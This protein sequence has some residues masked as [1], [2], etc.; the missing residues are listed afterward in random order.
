MI[1]RLHCPVPFILVTHPSYSSFFLSE[2]SP[3]LFKQSSFH[4]FFFLF[5][6]TQPFVFAFS[7][8]PPFGIW[9]PVLLV[10]Y[11][12]I[13][14]KAMGFFE[15]ACTNSR[16]S[17]NGLIALYATSSTDL[18]SDYNDVKT[19]SF[20]TKM[21]WDFG[22]PCFLPDCQRKKGSGKSQKNN[23][24]KKGSNLEHNKAWLLA[25]SG[26]GAEL[27]SA[28]PQSVHSSFRFSFC[29]QVEL[30]A[31][32]A[33]SLSSATVLMVNLD[34]G[35]SDDRATELKWR[36][37]ESLERS[38]SP[39][40]KSLV[41]FSY[42]EVV[43]ATRNFSKGISFMNLVS[44]I[45]FSKKKFYSYFWYGFLFLIGFFLENQWCRESFGERSI[46]LCF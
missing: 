26:G 39:V 44:F 7:L 28:D 6:K 38:I 10:A 8:F 41:R 5:S 46:E 17:K 12:E 45:C 30:E 27:T 2:N 20:F 23:G 13:C 37:I 9:E 31:I 3:P 32:T 16:T 1:L 11:I 40:A 29:S 22:F 25:E 14:F 34:N 43:S 24:E 18:Q 21:I 33:N 42:G 35:V 19:K 15:E 36:R 4:F